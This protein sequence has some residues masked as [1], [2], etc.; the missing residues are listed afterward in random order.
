M[1]PAGLTTNHNRRT[2]TWVLTFMLLILFFMV[3]KSPAFGPISIYVV[4][5][6]LKYF[7]ERIGGE[8]VKV[9][10]PAPADVDPAYW[11]PNV[12]EI[13]AYQKADL[14]L[15]NGAGYAKWINKVSLPRSK[16]VNTSRG[17]KDRYITTKAVM[18][19][20]HGAQGE[21]A[22]E[23]LTFTTW[24]D[25]EIS[26][27]QA[28][29]IAKALG[30]KRPEL[31]DVFKRNYESLK[32][33]LLA[34]DQKI[35]TIVSK[36]PSTPLIASHPVYDYF[37][38]RYGVNLVSVHWEPDELPVNQQWRELK[39]ILKQH[40][41]KWMIWEGAPVQASVIGLK[42]LGVNSLVFNPCGNVPEKG[43][44]LS[45]MDRNVENLRKAFD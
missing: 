38:R 18:T 14:I 7:A 45:V 29:V 11:T 5:Y 28:E 25:L 33:D 15:L 26:V 9:S 16:M 24:L 3:Q 1:K 2:Y 23:S 6:P 31:K 32:N 41:A 36:N 17:F 34:L 39:G 43:D 37:T 42:S 8:Y 21:H 44:F 19:H 4:N 35:Q 22:H 12:P 10:F 20:S 13:S 30:R 27:G 40:L